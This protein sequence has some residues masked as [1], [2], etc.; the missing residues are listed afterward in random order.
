MAELKQGL[1]NHRNPIEMS[2]SLDYGDALRIPDHLRV[3]P[4]DN[5][6]RNFVCPR[7]KIDDCGHNRAGA[8]PLAAAVAVGHGCICKVCQWGVLSVGQEAHTDCG[9]VIGHSIAD[10]TIIFDISKYLGA[11]VR[12]QVASLDDVDT[13]TV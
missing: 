13:R 7:G 5:R 8:T 9:G 3:I 4:R 2:G 10:S 1:T 6:R 12:L 11:E